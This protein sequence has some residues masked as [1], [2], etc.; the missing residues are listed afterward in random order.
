[1]LKIDIHT[2]I[3]PENLNE[4]TKDFND[5][6]FISIKPIDNNSSMLIKED[7]DFRKISCNCWDHNIRINDLKKTSV[8]IQ[9][10]S[11]IPI[12]FSYWANKDD[13]FLLSKYLNNHLSNIV[14]NNNQFLG[15]GTIPMQD[16]DYAISEMDRC[17]NELKLQ[18]IQIGTNV[19]G[20]NLS[21]LQFDPIFQHAEKIGCPIFIHPW[22]MFGEKHIEKYWLPWLVGMP[23]ETS[24]AICSLIFGGIFEKYPGLKNMFCSWR[25][26]FSIYNWTYKSWV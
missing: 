8:D 3:I 25:W 4:V 22:E 14:E 26:F 18:G 21:E 15:L 19:N 1:M 17:L 9:V 5:D 12:L 24:R 11:T 10:L 7:E 23:A 20:L 13:C 16:T 2:H 6:R